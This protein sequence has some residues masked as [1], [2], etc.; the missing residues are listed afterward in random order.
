MSNWLA[1]CSIRSVSPEPRT[2]KLAALRGR[3]RV[4]GRLST[5]TQAVRQEA[6]VLRSDP[7]A[8]LGALRTDEHRDVRGYAQGGREDDPVLRRMGRPGVAVDSGDSDQSDGGGQA[9]TAGLRLESNQGSHTDPA[10]GA[11]LAAQDSRTRTGGDL[12]ADTRQVREHPEAVEAAGRSVQFGQDRA[13][14]VEAGVRFEELE[15]VHA[16]EHH[17]ETGA[18]HVRLHHQPERPERSEA[19]A[20]A[21]RVERADC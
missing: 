8:L 16:T 10:L 6:T 11:S 7:L 14:A 2:A 15:R 9:Q 13:R 18:G 21:L 3:E 1:R 4:S 17:A 12:Q 5:A 20:A 19:A